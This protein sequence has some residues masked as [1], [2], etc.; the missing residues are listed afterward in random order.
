MVNW[1][2]LTKQLIEAARGCVSDPYPSA[3][4]AAYVMLEMMKKRV[5]N[6]ED[7]PLFIATMSVGNEEKRWLRDCIKGAWGAYSRVL[8]GVTK[9]ELKAFLTSPVSD[10]RRHS[11]ATPRSVRKLAKG[12]LNIKKKDRFAD[13]GSNWGDSLLLVA[14]TGRCCQVVGYEIDEMASMIANI[15]IRVAGLEKL[16]DS[17]TQD[18][19][20]LPEHEKFDAIL[21][22][23]PFGMRVMTESIRAFLDGVLGLAKLPANTSSDLLF[24]IRAVESLNPGGRCVTYITNGAAFG[25][26]ERLARKFLIDRNLLEAVV[27]L[28]AGMMTNTGIPATLLLLHKGRG[29]GETTVRFV[30][31][32]GLGKKEGRRVVLSDRE[33]E[34]ILAC[35]CPNTICEGGSCELP[36]YTEVSLDDIEAKDY[37]LTS[38]RYVEADM[39]DIEGGVALGEIIEARR[40]TTLS[41]KE[42][43][44]LRSDK[45]TQYRF[46]TLAAI[47]NGVIDKNELLSLKEIPA[48][49]LPYCAENGDIVLTKAGR[50]IKAAVVRK[51]DAER[52]L[53]C[54]NQY[55]VA[56]KDEWKSKVNPYFLKCY[57]DSPAGMKA[58]A[59]IVVGEVS[60]T[61]TLRDLYALK[62]PDPTKPPYKSRQRDI[63]ERYEAK[64]EE[65]SELRRRLGVA[66]AELVNIFNTTF[67]PEKG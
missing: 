50:P 60:P 16:A 45:P 12:L 65:V 28:P 64:K 62:V 24:T 46:I 29:V 51:S 54:A 63:E 14:E 52:I 33:I 15:R 42:Q 32:S 56:I 36:P 37:L 21:T 25:N 34:S 13:F 61:I 40:G 66:V 43:E 31:A 22:H 1:Q 57:F 4:A 6:V 38:R 11:L 59:H 5:Q 8:A 30:D 44:E 23:P 27:E 35:V 41:A 55:I 49:K 18:V 10:L 17:R 47:K 7:I 3:I 53:V 67:A 19:F 2:K 48:S 58:L 9:E 26:S 20:A 39:A